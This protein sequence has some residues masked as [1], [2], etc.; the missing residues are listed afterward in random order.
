MLMFNWKIGCSRLFLR[1]WL[2][3]IYQQTL[4]VVI[5]LCSWLNKQ[6]FIQE[7]YI[8][9]AGRM[10]WVVVYQFFPDKVLHKLQ[11]VWNLDLKIQ[12]NESKIESSGIFLAI[13][14]KWWWIYLPKG[15]FFRFREAA[16]PFD[17]GRHHHDCSIHTIE[18]RQGW[19]SEW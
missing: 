6:K 10:F 19:G 9:T 16:W 7:L 8:S 2:G 17:R 12:E 3:D 11:I 5:L 14:P 1:Y 13:W 4:K 15:C 18:Y